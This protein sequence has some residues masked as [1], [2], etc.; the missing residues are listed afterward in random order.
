MI[1]SEENDENNFITFVA[2][3]RF[4]HMLRDQQDKIV[5]VEMAALPG[6]SSVRFKMD[7]E[8]FEEIANA[9]EESIAHLQNQHPDKLVEDVTGCTSGFEGTK[10]VLEED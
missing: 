6:D 4:A 5:S 3:P 9:Y 7:K 8:T 1:P 2:D 10:D